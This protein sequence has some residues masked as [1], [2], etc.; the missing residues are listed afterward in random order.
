MIEGS[1]PYMTYAPQK[2]CHMILKKGAP[3]IKRAISPELENFLKKCLQRKVEKRLSAAELL[4][5]PFILKNAL[6]HSQLQP[7]M[8][9]VLDDMYEDDEEEEPQ[10]NTTI[11]WQAGGI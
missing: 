10:D 11:W 1:P 5:H 9:A 3:K 4:Q 2:A 7:L 6:E 8:Q